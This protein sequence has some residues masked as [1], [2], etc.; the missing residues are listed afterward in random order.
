MR[1]VGDRP[2]QRRVEE[3]HKRKLVEIENDDG[4]RGSEV[5][6]V[7]KKRNQNDQLDRSMDHPR[8]D[9]RGT[10]RKTEDKGEHAE[11]KRQ[12]SMNVSCLREK[13]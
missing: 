2:E 13:S 12:D 5:E 4:P 7:V 3:E 8:D 11:A 1:S 10:K 9:S 6:R